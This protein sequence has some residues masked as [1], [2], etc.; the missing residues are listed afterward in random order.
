MERNLGRGVGIGV[1][2]LALLLT[3][4]A[5]AGLALPFEVPVRTIVVDGAPDDW[6]GIAPAFEDGAGDSEC[7]AGTD[8]SALYLAQD[9]TYLYWRM[10][11]WSGTFDFSLND[12]GPS[13]RLH[14]SPLGKSV[15][16]VEARIAGTFTNIGS[17]DG[18]GWS[19]RFSGPE[20]GLA[21]QVAEGRIPLSMFDVGEFTYLVSSYFYRD[22][23]DCD[24][25]GSP[26]LPDLKLN[27][28][29]LPLLLKQG[30]LLDVT[31]SLDPGIFFDGLPAD[32][33]VAAVSPSGI[34]W[35]TLESGWIPSTEPLRAY[36]GPLFPLAP[37]SL[38]ETRN[39]PPGEYIFLFSVDLQMNGLWEEGAGD[40]GFVTVY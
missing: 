26:L 32:W 5:R 14:Q 7:G 13:L 20:Y 24:V 21:G 8:I 34:Y 29:D 17:W 23:V 36:G 16:D 28:S 38:L 33:W 27:G 2:V 10:D 25:A 35:Y 1:A 12:E 30:E 31:V 11:T 9:A 19:L 18:T 40:T 37:L 3:G 4:A 15:G 39:L 6:S 22:G